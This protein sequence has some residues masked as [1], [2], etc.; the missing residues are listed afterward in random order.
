ML[1]LKDETRKIAHAPL[2]SL[3]YK[4]ITNWLCKHHKSINTDAPV[5]QDRK[6]FTVHQKCTHVWALNSPI[7]VSEVAAVALL[8]GQAENQPREKSARQSSVG[9]TFQLSLKVTFS[10]PMCFGFSLLFLKLEEMSKPL[11]S[12]PPL[13]LVHLSWLASCLRQKISQE[14]NQG[15]RCC[16]WKCSSL[17]Q[18][19]M[20]FSCQ[21]PSTNVH[22]FWLLHWGS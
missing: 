1:L 5:N 7:C 13:C 20:H 3:P 2:L 8:L 17:S 18:A 22:G 10:L 19:S 11:H 16:S 21:I 6:L 15:F 14:V 9:G 4:Q 12:P